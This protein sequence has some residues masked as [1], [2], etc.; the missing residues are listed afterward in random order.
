MI[1][2][3]QNNSPNRSYKVNSFRKITSILVISKYNKYNSDNSVI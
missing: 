3:T 1:I 2:I